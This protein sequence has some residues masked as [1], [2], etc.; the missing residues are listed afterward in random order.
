MTEKS[1]RVIVG[2]DVGSVSVDTFFVDEAG[3]MLG[4]EYTRHHGQP[5]GVLADRLSLVEGLYKIVGVAATGAG[6]KRLERSIGALAVNE[7]VAQVEAAKA[8]YP[9]VRS[10]IDIGGQDSKFIQL[11]RD[12]HAGT[13]AIRLKDFSVSSMCA[14]GTGSFLD[15]QSSRLGLSIEREFGEA[16]LRSLHPGRIAGRCSVFAKSDMI[17]LQ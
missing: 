5:D 17:H 4:G 16:A 12:S 3:T 8:F 15:Q 13:D 7:V 14:S 9:H 1:R 11:E 6:A 10:I 2:I